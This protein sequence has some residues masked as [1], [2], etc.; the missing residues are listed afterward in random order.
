M[1][2]RRD[3]V[4]TALRELRPRHPSPRLRRGVADALAAPA[5]GVRTERARAPA[6]I[7]WLAASGVAAAAVLAVWLGSP[8]VRPVVPAAAGAPRVEP[9]TA[10]APTAPVAT[11][12]LPSPEAWWSDTVVLGAQDEGVVMADAGGPVRRYRCQLVDHVR[13]RNDQARAAYEAF[14]PREEVVQVRLPLQ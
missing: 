13:W 12:V 7:P 5:G 4:E 2:D 8:W 10:D 6:W 11:T 1:N 14:A 3:P 9:V